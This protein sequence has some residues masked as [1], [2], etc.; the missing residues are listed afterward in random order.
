MQT[1]LSEITKEKNIWSSR[2][3]CAEIGKRLGENSILYWAWKNDIP[4]F[5][6]GITDGAVGSQIWLFSQTHA[7]TLDILR[8]EQELSDLFFDKVGNVG[9]LIIGGGIAKHHLIWWSQFRGG[10]DGAV[11]VTSAPEWD[12]SLSGARIREGISWGKLKEN[13]KHLTI[14]GD[15]T[16]L[17]PLMATALINRLSVR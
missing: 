14:E 3:L 11:Y 4:V 5:V 13:S 7:F 2:E 12:G 16:V 8:D 17:L 9:A 15:A 10:L 6:P 1:W